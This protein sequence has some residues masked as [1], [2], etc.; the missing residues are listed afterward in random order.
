MSV[1]LGP[2]P[3]LWTSVTTPAGWTVSRSYVLR[4]GG[5]TEG[6][7]VPVQRPEDLRSGFPWNYEQL[8][9]ESTVFTLLSV[10]LVNRH[11]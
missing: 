2:S 4:T 9:K 3:L 10:S 7:R 6:I 5:E 1:L 11:Q 8:T